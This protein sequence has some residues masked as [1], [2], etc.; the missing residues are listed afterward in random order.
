MS[1]RDFTSDFNEIKSMTNKIRSLNES[2][3]F[4]DE[5]ED[6][7]S[8]IGEC[9]GGECDMGRMEP[10]TEEEELQMEA[11]DP[12]SAVNKIREIALKGMVALCQTPQDPQ[13][14][15]LKQ[16]F[17]YCDKANKKEKEE[18]K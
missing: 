11:N 7:L 4:A 13:Y 5:Y 15:V 18:V 9:E 14:E 16:I 17:N 3:S 10:E 1:K 6:D 2:I 12:S 8:D